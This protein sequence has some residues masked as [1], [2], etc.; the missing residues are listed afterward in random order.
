MRSRAISFPSISQDPRGGVEKKEHTTLLGGD[1][2]DGDA[3]LS[4]A[5]GTSDSMNIVLDLIR[6]V[7]VDHITNVL[8]VCE[9]G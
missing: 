8:D 6:H 7:V 9:E 1:E 2:R 5:T 3:S 4:S